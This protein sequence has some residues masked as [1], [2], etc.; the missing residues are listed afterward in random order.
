MERNE[1]YEELLNDENLLNETPTLKKSLNNP[2]VIEGIY[3]LCRRTYLTQYN[4]SVVKLED[5]EYG[6]YIKQEQFQSLRD[7]FDN[8]LNILEIGNNQKQLLEE[9]LRVIK[10]YYIKTATDE[11]V[12]SKSGVVRNEDNKNFGLYGVYYNFNDI[13]WN[14]FEKGLGLRK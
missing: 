13:D 10:G 8:F 2:K 9:I 1:F 7:A 4:A 14:Y 5:G 11:E 6:C 3:T 12:S